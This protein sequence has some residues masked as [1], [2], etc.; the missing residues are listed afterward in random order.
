VD[1]KELSEDQARLRE[2][3][4]IIPTNSEP[5]KQFL[6]K[7]VKQELQIE[8]LQKQVRDSQ[9]ALDK[10]SQDYENYVKNLTAN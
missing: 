4:K 2:N 1:L 10:K 6:E 3:L 8:A 9:V 7:F 5:Y